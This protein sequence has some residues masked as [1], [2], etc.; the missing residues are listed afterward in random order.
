MTEEKNKSDGYSTNFEQHGIYFSCYPART[1][2]V[3]SVNILNFES[4]FLTCPRYALD[5][6]YYRLSYVL[7]YTLLSNTIIITP[8]VNR[9]SFIQ[10]MNIVFSFFQF[11]SLFSLF[12]TVITA[13]IVHLLLFYRILLFFPASW[14][15]VTYII[16]ISIYISISIFIRCLISSQLYN[17]NR[18]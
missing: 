3:Y 17:Y 11:F 14:C 15:Y 12:Y 16:S 5:K 13:I 8:H 6:I 1:A 4:L 2:F 18:M 9:T 10:L 7:K